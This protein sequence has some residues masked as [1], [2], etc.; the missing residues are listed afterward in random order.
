MEKRNFGQLKKIMT[1]EELNEFCKKVT[2]EYAKY[3]HRFSRT[4]F[5]EKYEVTVSCFYKILEYSVIE[6]LVEDVIVRK[7]MNKA[8]ENQNLH[9]N[10]AGSS[11]I[12]KYSRMYTKRYKNIATN[13]SEEE[14][15][16][17][18]KDFG[19]NPDIGKGDFASS[20]GVHPRVIDYILKR[21]II[22]NISD[23][24][25]VDAIEKRSIANAK[26]TQNVKEYFDTLRKVREENKK[27][28]SLK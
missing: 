23:N 9:K 13:M 18:A 20:Y 3:D 12:L 27:E 14:I 6:N 4:Y 1:L 2:E 5:C 21:A 28:I 8:I 10:G 19:D 7:M 24:N 25:V 17:I 11:S 15:R 22:E 16:N 26:N